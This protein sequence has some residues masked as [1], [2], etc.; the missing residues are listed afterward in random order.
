MID[1]QQRIHG[2]RPGVQNGGLRTAVL[3][4][5]TMTTALTAG[6]FVD[7][8]ITIMPG[9][10]DVDDRTFVETFQSLD[11]AINNPLF[12][13]VGFTG[14]LLS[15]GLAVALYL[16]PER[17]PVLIW[18]GAAMVCYLI[19]CVI[20]IGVHEPLNET[21]RTARLDGNTDFAALRAELD[22][23]MWTTWNSVRAVASVIGF[24]CLA[25]ALVIH[26]QFGQIPSRRTTR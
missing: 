13:G 19:V 16:R 25:W 9:L 5:A 22:E 2:Q 1:R 7:W 10:N 14:A 8:S 23:T 3:I 6:I 11:E 24:G 26:R 20:T 18:V 21:I 12:I 17:R 15:T 4:V